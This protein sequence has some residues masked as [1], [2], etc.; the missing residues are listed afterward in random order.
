MKRIFA[1]LKELSTETFFLVIFLLGLGS[2]IATYIPSIN[3]IIDLKWFAYLA[4]PVS[5]IGANYRV[6]VRLTAKNYHA[7]LQNII[8]ELWGNQR[9]LQSMVYATPLTLRDE[10][11]TEGGSQNIPEI[12][13]DL[14]SKIN[15]CYKNI[16]GAK[17]I[18]QSLQRVPLTPDGS[19]LDSGP[20][21]TAMYDLLEKAKENIQNII[22]ELRQT[23]RS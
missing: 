22:K 8:N 17:E 23:C 2:T 9:A 6:Y 15:D 14:R 11:W 21:L 5:F 1:Y 12:S 19:P 18:H 10:A 4:I 16:R 7:L 3:S 20:E 13:V